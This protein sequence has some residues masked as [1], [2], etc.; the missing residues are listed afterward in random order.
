MSLLLP[1]SQTLTTARATSA[2]P[3][4]PIAQWSAIS[5]ST[6]SFLHSSLTSAISASVS[7]EK[8]LIETTG[9]M[10]NFCM[11]STWRCEIGHAGFERLEV[12]LLE[13]LLLDAAVHLERADGG[14]QHR[15]VGREP[16]LAALDVEELL[17]A[18][19]G[20]EARLGHHVVAELERGR[21]RQHRVAAVRDVGE[22]AA[23]DEGGRAFERLH[24][25]GRRAPP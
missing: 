18:E 25:I 17:A 14:D 5:A 21:G 12:L 7:A 13:V 24:Q 4:P 2:A 6:P 16:G 9:T 20:A 15:A 23:M 8:R 10:P 11:F 1:L 22:R 19:I 3:S